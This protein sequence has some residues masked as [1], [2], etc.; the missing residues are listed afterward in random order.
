MPT[1]DIR[2]SDRQ[3]ERGGD[4]VDEIV[5]AGRRRPTHRI[6]IRNRSDGKHGL[7]ER[8]GDVA[9]QALLVRYGVNPAG[10]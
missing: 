6:G 5:D 2:R 4:A 1:T 9:D 7:G 3:A 10:T 8:M